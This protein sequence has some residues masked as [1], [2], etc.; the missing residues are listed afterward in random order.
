MSQLSPMDELFC[1]ASVGETVS[2]FFSYY[3]YM[4]S[5][6]LCIILVHV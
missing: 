4:R 3:V 5:E 1:H 2:R 6:Y